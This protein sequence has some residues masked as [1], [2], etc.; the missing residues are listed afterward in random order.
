[1]MMPIYVSYLYAEG[2]TESEDIIEDGAVLF[3]EIG[4]NK[5]IQLSVLV[6][7]PRFR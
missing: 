1:M 2:G 6:D 5:F 7:R 3:G 4:D